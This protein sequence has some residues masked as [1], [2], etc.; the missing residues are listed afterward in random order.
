MSAAKHTPDGDSQRP[1]ARLIGPAPEGSDDVDD[2]AITLRE[3]IGWAL[4]VA[5]VFW[6]LVGGVVV[7]VKFISG[8]VLS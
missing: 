4:F 8:W 3:A 7:A 1:P 6:L 2:D 5:T